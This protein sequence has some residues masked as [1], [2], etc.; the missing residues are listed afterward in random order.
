MPAAFG[1]IEIVDFSRVLAGP[2]ATMLLADFG[3][4][5]LKVERPGGG[6]DTRGWGPPYDA[7]G[8]A[9][10]FQAI[11][12]NKR[13]VV[14]DL[15]ETADRNEAQRLALEADVVVENFRPGVMERFGLGYDDLAPGNPSLIYSSIT[16]FGRGSG[17]DLPGYDL[18]IQA[19]GGLMSVT[20]SPTGEPQKVGVALVDV[21]AGLFSALGIMAALR[22]RDQTGEGQRVD[23]SLLLSILAAL[24]NQAAAWT[25]AGEIPTR[26]GND[27]PSVTP[28]GL[29][30]A[31]DG[32]LVVAVG[33]Q[34]QFVAFCEAIGA[35]E[36]LDDPRF[37]T[38]AA[39]VT[40]R[41]ELRAVLEARLGERTAADWA[42]LLSARRV[43]AGT[44][45]DISLAFRL[46]EELG[47]D[48]IVELPREDG[49]AVRLPRNPVDLSKTPASYRWAPPRLPSASSA[50]PAE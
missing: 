8:D 30:R 17:A 33:N 50:R 46:A 19:L 32:D 21:L 47:L 42:T 2:F 6:D 39:R 27:H 37:D 28:Y 15:G 7:A 25:V 10:Y 22:H 26:L 38:N 31:A 36:V 14:L 44:V 12:R 29:L 40:H 1:D 45:N 34:R 13:S 48:P 16:G 11:N 35:P 49:T 18:L 24:T 3:A 43:P 20:G 41:D 4:R 23:V 9:T 5:V